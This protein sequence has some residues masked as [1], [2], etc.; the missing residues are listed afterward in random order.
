MSSGGRFLSQWAF[1][2]ANFL[3]RAMAIGLQLFHASMSNPRIFDYHRAQ[4]YAAIQIIREACVDIMG[5]APS[6]RLEYRAAET[7]L[8]RL[9]E[10]IASLTGDRTIVDKTPHHGSAAA[11]ALESERHDVDTEA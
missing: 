2:P 3:T 11:A 8:A 7:L 9:D 10:A 4:F 5:N 1:T 6:E